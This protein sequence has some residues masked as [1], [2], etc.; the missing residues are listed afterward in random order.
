[1]PVFS[2]TYIYG[3]EGEIEALVGEREATVGERWY[4]SCFQ[5]ALTI[6]RNRQCSCGLRSASNRSK[7]VARLVAN[8]FPNAGL[9]A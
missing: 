2:I 1:M 6:R 3:G 7:L 9:S 5:R 8:Y 4:V